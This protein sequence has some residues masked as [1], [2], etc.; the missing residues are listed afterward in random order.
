MCKFERVLIPEKIPLPSNFSEI[1]QFVSV[2]ITKMMNCK[3][4]YRQASSMDL[5][6]MFI[7]P[8]AWS[9]GM[10]VLKDL[11]RQLKTEKRRLSPLIGKLGG[12]NPSSHT[13]EVWHT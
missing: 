5:S 11:V 7:V 1:S 2:N 12:N 3:S 6:H 4:S 13:E 10:P 9:L 8:L